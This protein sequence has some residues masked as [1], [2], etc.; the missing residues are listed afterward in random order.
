[1]DDP[2]TVLAE[3]IEYYRARAGEYD[4]WWDR[5]GRYERG[6]D[7]T[8]AWF[9]ERQVVLTA[10]D[11]LGL[12]GNVLELAPGT[13]I[14]T[15]RLARTARAVTAIDASEE[16]IDLN[17]QRLG[18]A[19]ARVEYVV[20][21]LFEWHPDR[22]FD[23]VVFG[24]WLSHVPRGRLASFIET[25]ARS[26][27]PRGRVFFVDGKREPSSTA[28]DHVLRDPSE[29]LMTRRLNDRTEYRIVKNFWSAAELE[30]RFARAGLRVD[31]RE[32]ELYFQY[33][34]GRVA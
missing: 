28:T 23:A 5:R 33:G 27:G 9:A 8:A 21:D 18:R 14:W 10:F 25:V 31:V 2:E 7:A 4:E 19:A 1:M 22:T 13:G 12:T 6:P 32:T 34:V 17:R 24:F 15:E 29:E 20:A 30:R 26:L 3:Q 16:M 11:R